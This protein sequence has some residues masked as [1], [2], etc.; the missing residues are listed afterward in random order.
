MRSS[1]IVGRA[2]DTLFV[3][4]QAVGR[5]FL[6]SHGAGELGVVEVVVGPARGE[7]LG[8]VA[9]LDDAAVLHHEDEVGVPDRREPVG[10]HE[11]RP[12]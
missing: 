5:L 10:D 12:L 8:V 4:Q 1:H 11:A 3:D 9:L 7:Q 2:D 6:F